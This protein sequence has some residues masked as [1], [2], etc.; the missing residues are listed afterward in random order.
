M[1]HKTLKS[2]ALLVTLLP[3]S[4]HAQQAYP[5][6]C[7][8]GG[9][10]ETTV[11]ANPGASTVSLNIRFLR[12]NGAALYGIGVGY[13]AWEDR[14]VD[15]NEPDLILYE[16]SGQIFMFCQGTAC[17]FNSVDQNLMHIYRMIES[18]GDF[19]VNVYNDGAGFMRVVSVQ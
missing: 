18:G 16:S 15:D 7:R 6:V 1:L 17:S 10:M 13:C 9:G 2:L 19:T 8:G 3:V 5:L 4:S 14:G 11:I 12:Q